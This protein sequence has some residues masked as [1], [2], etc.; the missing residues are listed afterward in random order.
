MTPDGADDYDTQI[1]IESERKPMKRARAVDEDLLLKVLREE[2]DDSTSY[3]TSELAR[4]QSD[5][6]DR[7]HA[8]PYGEEVPNRS[9]VVTHDIEDTINWVM[10]HL[11]RVFTSADDLISCDDDGLED[12]DPA[13]DT[14]AK[15]LRH[16]FF[17]DNPGETNLHDFIFDGLLQKIGC[18]R[19]Y[20]E[21]PEPCPPQELEGV[22]LDVVAKYVQDPNYE[23]LEAEIEGDISQLA[24]EGSQSVAS[25]M[26]GAGLMGGMPTPLM[27][28][29]D[30]YENM[31]VSIKVQKKNRVGRGKVAIIPPEE[32]RISRRAKCLDTA[33]YHAWKY[34]EWLANLVGDH[35]DKAFELDPNYDPGTVYNDDTDA[36]S[37]ERIQARFPDEPFAGERGHRKDAERR[38]VWVNIEYIR[39]DFDGDNVVELRRIKRFGN[40]ILENDV[41]DCTEFVAWSPIRVSHRLIGR[42][43]ADTLM[44]IQKIR[45][46]LTRKAM[47]S[48]TQSLAPRTYINTQAAGD[49]PSVLDRILDHEVGDVIPIAGNPR[50]ALYTEVTPDVSASAFQAI[51]YWDRRSE[52]AS[53]VNRHA[54]GIQP[55]AITQTKGGIEMLQ[56]AANSRVEQVARWAALGFEQILTKLLHL[57]VTHQDQPRIIKV[58]G[59][60]LEVDPRR[61][62][63]EMTVSVHVGMAAESREKKLAYLNVIAS[64]QEA[65][66]QQAGLDNPLTSPK[67][68]RNTLAQ[69]VSTMGYKQPSAFFKEIDPN[70]QPPPQ[71]ED[72]KTAEIKQKGELAQAELQGK[73][74]LA[75]AEQQTKMQAQAAEIAGKQ[76]IAEVE[77]QFR[78]RMAEMELQV[79]ERE[80]ERQA[81]LQR[82]IAEMKAN[83][84]RETAQARLSQERELALLNIAMQ[85][86]LAEKR[87]AAGDTAGKNFREGGRL[88]A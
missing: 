61:W 40:T 66:M 6:M 65:I 70:W 39:G 11:L 57:I 26:Q 13:L 34:E 22:S 72:P 16:V 60:R 27:P 58:A 52:E 18:A 10:P 44:D 83:L 73:Q 47:D 74:Q 30:P 12:D 41:V 9:A 53:G 36:I 85:R 45:T 64:K 43:L 76:Q 32:L 2:E 35:P 62:S 55:Q 84:E 4:A 79:K 88:D 46:V 37:D 24:L 3:Y 1:E 14:A 23:I 54:M 21:D 49:D 25:P 33:D 28:Q 42:S 68:Y 51:E 48:L 80:A 71:G 81:E 69:M 8:K 38:K 75:Q 5:A 82:A 78:Q 77:M 19:V 7:Y 17:K 56:A 29:A 50:D 15:Y 67:E 31:R 59:K 87:I 86:E 20:W 63:D